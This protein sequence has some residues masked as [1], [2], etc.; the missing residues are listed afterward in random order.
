MNK[1]SASTDVV[2]LVAVGAQGFIL[3]RAIQQLRRR[4]VNPD[5]KDPGT[6]HTRWLQ[7]IVLV[8]MVAVVAIGFA[9]VRAW[10][11]VGIFVTLVSALLVA[12]VATVIAAYLWLAAEDHR[13]KVGYVVCEAD[14][15]GAPRQVKSAM[16][17]IY[18]SARTVRMGRAHQEAMFGDLELDQLVFS[19]A[20]QAILCS[21]ISTGI[22][23]L[24][25]DSDAGDHELIADADGQIKQIAA[26][27]A[28]V[29]ATLKRAASAASRLSAR[30][31]E[32]ERVQAAQKAVYE[33]HAAAEDRRRQAREKLEQVTAE[34]K[35]MT[36][37][38]ATDVDD[39]IAAVA[40]GYDEVLQVSGEAVGGGNVAGHASSAQNAPAVGAGDANARLG[41]ALRMAKS[42]AG[43]AVKDARARAKAMKDQFGER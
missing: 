31:A 9:T 25:P 43:H 34:A 27:L 4:A 30:I 7:L 24:K 15:L 8:S 2:S 32:P 23:D 42:A 13:R 5:M 33:A 22:R 29:E 11:L 6:R 19:A 35:T 21:E 39:R 26:H 10:G 41:A 18:G 40:A 37:V 28:E 12:V 36:R 3:F 17:R 14:Y 16:R 20:Q 38:D 1:N